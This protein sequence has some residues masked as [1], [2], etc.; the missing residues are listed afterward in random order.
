M[1][2]IFFVLR[3]IRKR[4]GGWRVEGGGYDGGLDWVVGLGCGWGV[5]GVWKGKG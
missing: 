5:E 3:L 1:H 2:G 4:G